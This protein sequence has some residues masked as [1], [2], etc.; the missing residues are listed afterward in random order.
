MQGQGDGASVPQEQSYLLPLHRALEKRHASI[1]EERANLW[2][3]QVGQSKYLWT[4]G[5]INICA[6]NRSLIFPPF[7]CTKT[8]HKQLQPSIHICTGKIEIICTTRK[9]L[10]ALCM[11]M[12]Q[13]ANSPVSNSTR[14]LAYFL[15]SKLLTYHGS[16]L[17]CRVN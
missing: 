17:P 13:P 4:A 10:Q 3:S 5:D 11:K 16:R 7:K 9:S 2:R 6:A 8:S 1:R 15:K 14:S 12:E